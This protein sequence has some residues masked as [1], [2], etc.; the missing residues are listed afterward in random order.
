M[1]SMDL[2]GCRYSQLSVT[3]LASVLLSLHVAAILVRLTT[4]AS[5]VQPLL[6]RIFLPDLGARSPLVLITCSSPSNMALEDQLT[7]SRALSR[8]FPARRSLPPR[9]WGEGPALLGP[10]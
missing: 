7:S 9:S 3:A 6:P 10:G 8:L 2:P 4:L 5:T 1:Y